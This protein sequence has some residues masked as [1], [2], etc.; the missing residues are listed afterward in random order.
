MARYPEFFGLEAWNPKIT[1]PAGK[2]LDV[3]PKSPTYN[4][5]V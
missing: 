1:C 3:D 4:Q 5:C 2:K